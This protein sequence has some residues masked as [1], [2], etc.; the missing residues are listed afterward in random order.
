[1]DKKGQQQLLDFKPLKSSPVQGEMKFEDN[2]EVREDDEGF[3][4]LK[5]H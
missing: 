3:E 4:F 1:M 5:K 2:F